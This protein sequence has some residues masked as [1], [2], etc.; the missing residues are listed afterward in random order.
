MKL[1][2]IKKLNELEAKCLLR[3]S[4]ERMSPTKGGDGG[5]DCLWLG[6]LSST[7]HESS[8][9]SLLECQGSNGMFYRNP[10]RRDNNNV[11]F[12]HFFSRDMS[13]GVLAHFASYRSYYKRKDIPIYNFLPDLDLSTRYA[14]DAWLHWIDNNRECLI[15]KPKW[16]GG[17][18][19]VRHPI[20]RFAPDDRS[21]ITPDIWS[22]MS[23]V[24]HFNGWKQHKQMRVHERSYEDFS[25]IQ[26]ENVDKGYQ[27]HLKVVACYI[28]WK[29]GVSKEYR[30]KI[31]NVCYLK[32]PD[33]L[34]F[35]I[36]SQE[37]VYADDIIEYLSML[38]RIESFEPKPTW[39]W[40]QANILEKL[41]EKSYC[42]WD[43]IFLGR[44]I[45]DYI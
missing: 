43:L 36:V 20:Y 35:K 2:L 1:Q 11:G 15:K 6:L 41:E 8:A 5:D 14:K 26:A 24:W 22:L 25:L 19:A 34:F 12:S 42:G 39:L 29:M 21:Y 31:S 40:E 7:R 13:L 30:Q 16:L 23:Q 17:G 27:T 45:L 3:E 38:P 9:R 33:N 28:R 32:N 18:C 10:T 4:S 44:I 37:N